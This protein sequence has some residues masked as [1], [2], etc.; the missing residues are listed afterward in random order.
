MAPRH[1]KDVLYLVADDLRN[2]L[3]CYGRHHVR[4][5]HLDALAHSATV[6]DRAYCQ[7]ARCAPSR[8]SFLT[9]RG[10]QTTRVLTS[11]PWFRG[12][13]PSASE[14]RTLPEHLRLAG[15]LTMGMGKLFPS[16]ANYDVP[17]SWS[18]DREYL[19]YDMQ[20]CAGVVDARKLPEAELVTGTW[21][22]LSGPQTQFID[23]NLSTHAM[24]SLDF[25]A[26]RRKRAPA[27]ADGDVQ[28]FGLFVGFIR[29]HGPWMVPTHTWQSY[30]TDQIVLPSARGAAYPTGAP[31]VAAH[32]STLWVPPH[33]DN[34]TGR[35]ELPGGPGN[36]SK[37]DTTPYTPVEAS[38]VREA[39]HAYY[40]AV[41]WLD[42]QVCACMWRAPLPH[43]AYRLTL[44]HM[45]VH[46]PPASSLLCGVPR[47]REQVGRILSKLDAHGFTAHT[48]VVLHGDHGYHLGE[49]YVSP[50]F[51]TTTLNLAVS[52]SFHGYHLGEQDVPN[53]IST[54][55]S[56]PHPPDVQ[57]Q[58]RHVPTCPE[59]PS[60]RP[61][62][63]IAPCMSSALWRK[64]NTFELS[65]RVPLLIRAPWK[66]ASTAQRAGVLV[67]LLD[68]YPT[69]SALIGAPT[70]DG[71]GERATP[72]EGTDLSSVFDDPSGPR[73]LRAQDG[74]FSLMPRCA[75]S[76]RA[77]VPYTGWCRPHQPPSYV[78][79]TLRTYKWRYTAWVRWASVW[80]STSQQKRPSDSGSVQELDPAMSW[81]GGSADGS[82]SAERTPWEEHVAMWREG[83]AFAELYYFDPSTESMRSGP[84]GAREMAD[85]AAD[86]A[87]GW[88][89]SPSTH[90]PLRS[91]ASASWPP[92]R[93]P[94]DACQ[95]DYDECEP[96]NLASVPALAPIVSA[97][98]DRVREY[99]ECQQAH[100]CAHPA[101]PPPPIRPDPPTPP[102]P[103]AP[104]PPCRD[105][106]GTHWCVQRH[107]HL[108]PWQG[109][110]SACSEYL[111]E[112]CPKSCGVCSTLPPAP[113]P[114][115]PAPPRTPQPHTPPPRLPPA[116]P[117]SS[118]HPP[119]PLPPPP[120]APPPSP[121]PQLPPRAASA[122]P[123]DP[124]SLAPAS[125]RPVVVTPPPSLR[126]PNTPSS[127]GAASIR[128]SPPRAPSAALEASSSSSHPDTSL[129]AGLIA[130]SVVAFV[131]YRRST[132]ASRMRACLQHRALLPSEEL[133][134][135]DAG[136]MAMGVPSGARVL[137]HAEAGD[138]SSKFDADC[139]D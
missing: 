5:P 108:M 126:V 6:F 22:A 4:T 106:Q 102:P 46:V 51:P 107:E 18:S 92:D 114:P 37:V 32:S 129:V 10:P 78:G 62:P 120:R 118:P 97:M 112:R 81:V 64:F 12:Y 80:R 8:M 98:H 1:R 121:P 24:I 31:V 137:V 77:P 136:A 82:D 100:A 94:M 87:G 53:A 40:A 43:L 3:P 133:Q 117:H 134:H 130:V 122:S 11:S 86:A 23:H 60:E 16:N 59:R 70:P 41:T 85:A 55:R 29:P 2:E 63:L 111:R 17:R 131:A 110:W 139:V 125:T 61:L 83:A 71:P 15:W 99:F 69:V 66:I 49:Q 33:R 28:P 9:G 96:A 74:A 104:P 115:P 109:S 116:H 34:A 132:C 113:P 36:A 13:H 20:R 105:I 47:A 54:S 14:W 27:G 93:L 101:P 65:A 52:P 103:A 57:T 44:A 84:V 21:C 68:L 124:P 88:L 75:L 30:S 138:S 45:F 128:M 19:G 56:A 42:E 127:S 25:I 50:H 90:A 119:S 67:E 89:D 35:G 123:S 39:R 135:E 91:N 7:L 76:A 38:V 58:V 79:Y 48:L 72:L 26:A 73:A 95:I